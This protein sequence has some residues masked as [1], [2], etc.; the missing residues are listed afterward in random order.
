M[1]SHKNSISFR[2]RITFAI[3]LFH[4]LQQAVL[5]AL[6]VTFL[7]AIFTIAYGLFITV[8]NVRQKRFAAGATPT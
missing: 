4:A 5:R 8:T 1:L 6:Y 7:A 3:Y 2:L